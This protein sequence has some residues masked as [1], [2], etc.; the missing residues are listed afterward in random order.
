MNIQCSRCEKILITDVSGKSIQNLHEHKIYLCETCSNEM[1]L[2]ICN[3]G[4]VMKIT[5]SYIISEC[6]CGHMTRKQNM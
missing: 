3:C 1:G 2:N 5:N 4:N 6:D